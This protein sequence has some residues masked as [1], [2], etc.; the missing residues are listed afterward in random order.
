[1]W[2]EK[3]PRNEIYVEYQQEK[4]EYDEKEPDVMKGEVVAALLN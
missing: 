1:M 3:L 2:C 4:I